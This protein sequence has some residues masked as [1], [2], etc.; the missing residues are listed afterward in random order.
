MNETVN[1]K[2][3]ET[4]ICS[5]LALM[6]GVERGHWS[7][8]PFLPSLPAGPSQQVVDFLCSRHSSAWPH[9]K[10]PYSPWPLI[11]SRFFTSTKRE[12]IRA[13]HWRGKGGRLDMQSGEQEGSFI[14]SV[15]A[16]NQ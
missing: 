4:G 15:I 7:T 16:S 1:G 2:E 13:N 9:I 12:R 14:L 8:N 5:P 10:L 11:I 3:L 6:V